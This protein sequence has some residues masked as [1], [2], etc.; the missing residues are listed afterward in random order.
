[1]AQPRP[2]APAENVALDRWVRRGGRVLLFA[3]PAL[4]AE[5]RFPLGDRRR[6]QDTLLLSPILARWGLL[7]EFDEA[8]LARA[9]GVALG[10]GA[11]L[12]VDLPGRFALTDESSCRVSRRA[13]IARC[14]VGRGRVTAVADAA[15][16]EAP[17]DDANLAGRRRA[18]ERLVAAAF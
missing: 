9:R 3:D 16:F 14:A 1:M 12:P 17:A 4:T 2:L 5:S 6:P 7:L 8:Q 11:T 18:L 13:L 10:R 15:L